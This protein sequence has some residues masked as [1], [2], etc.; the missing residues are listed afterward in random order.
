MSVV[1]VRDLPRVA[2][3]PPSTRRLTVAHALDDFADSAINL[4][5]VGSLFFSVS[6]DAS[7]ERILVYLVLTAL[8]L[9]LVAPVVGPVLDRSRLGHRSLLA[10]TH[11]VRAAL[12]LA[13]AASLG[14]LRFYPLVFGVLLSRKAYALARTALLARLVTDE[15][16]L[17]AA[18]GHLARTG[19]VAGGAGIL[20]AS[21]LLAVTSVELLPL[22]GAAG[23]VAA[24]VVSSSIRVPRRSG[25]GEAVSDAPAAVPETVRAASVAVAALHAAA[26]ALTF[27]L[28]L[29]IKRGG[30]DVWVSGTALV[31][32]GAGGFVGTAVAGRVHRRL[33]PDRVIV[34][35]LLGPG[36]VALAG[37]L[38]IGQL[39]ILVIATGLGMGASVAARSMDVLYGRVHEGVRASVISRSELRFQVANVAGA[40][41]AVLVAPGPRVGFG[42][43]GIVLLTAAA[44]FASN[45]QLSL[46]LEAGR[47]I[48][49]ERLLTGESALG[50]DLLDEAE[51]A[52][53]RHRPRVAMALAALAAR[54]AE[55]T[56][57]GGPSAD[58]NAVL[59]G[60]AAGSPPADG[61]D[62]IR[63][64]RAIDEARR[65]LH[66]L[67][68]NTTGGDSVNPAARTS[69]SPPDHEPP[70]T[71]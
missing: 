30:G 57:L 48:S 11:V 18:S 60:L 68:T 1:R 19:T 70:A 69:P 35:C 27:L 39:G 20:A 55:G 5:M 12:S 14:S 24:A 15:A 25:T 40:S 4:S 13:L 67:G 52:L 28:A 66:A 10:G 59:D 62:R 6:F 31:A 34:L 47:L 58:V 37:V 43:V 9:A 41:L 45:R 21:A 53:A 49:G 16:E 2:L 3:G 22:V 71:R 56:R 65:A 7:R 29:A 61:D 64:R 32:A 33:T 63:A 8:P 51:Y 54:I 42:A 50:D 46:R 36:A 17:V 44:I 38:S 23:Y 26:G